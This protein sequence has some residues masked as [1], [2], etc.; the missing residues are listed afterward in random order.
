M[1]A[2]W[3]LALAL[4]GCAASPPEQA[5][6]SPSPAPEAA[7]A[8]A[9]TPPSADFAPGAGPAAAQAPSPVAPA[10]APAASASPS[11]TPDPA[12]AARA[13]QEKKVRAQVAAAK[14]TADSLTA[15]A[16]TE[17]PDLKPGELRHPGAIARC[18]QMRADAAQAVSDY[19]ALKKEARDA[20]F[21]VQ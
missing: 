19:E 14:A 1:V 15:K 9:V 12:E 11:A 17:C 4:Q 6:E 10:V 16:D 8:P 7:Q 2:A 21:A 5:R 3:L 18:A 13:E 20:G